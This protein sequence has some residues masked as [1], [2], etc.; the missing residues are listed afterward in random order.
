MLPLSGAESREGN[1]SHVPSLPRVEG[2]NPLDFLRDFTLVP[3]SIALVDERYVAALYE[4]S[5]RG[6]YAVVVFVADCSQESCAIVDLLGYSLLEGQLV[7][8]GP[9]DDLHVKIQISQTKGFLE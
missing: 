9:Y 5:R 7:D 4:D 6:L 8:S 3:D 1:P 2:E